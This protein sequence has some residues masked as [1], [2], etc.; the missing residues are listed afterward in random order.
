[1]SPRR[2]RP[3]GFFPI[4]LLA[5]GGVLAGLFALYARAPDPDVSQVRIRNQTGMPVQQVEVNGI[6]YGDIPAG[7]TSGYRDMKSAYGY[8][9]VQ[10]LMNGTRM[11]LQP[12]D[13]VGEQ[14]LGRGH[15]T[16]VILTRQGATMSMID[17]EAV[18][19]AD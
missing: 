12:E 7:A 4:V 8:A 10:L 16:Y 1:M 11:R 2:I 17:I 15:F 6:D 14:A 5:L 19:D 18:K 13:Y 3:S 9:K